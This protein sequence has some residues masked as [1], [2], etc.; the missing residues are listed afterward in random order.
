MGLGRKGVPI[1]LKAQMLGPEVF[2]LRACRVCAGARKKCVGPHTRPLD[3]LL[4][5]GLQIPQ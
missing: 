1:A 4:Y 3:I 5:K 2:I